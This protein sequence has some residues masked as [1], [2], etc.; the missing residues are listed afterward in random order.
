MEFGSDQKSEAMEEEDSIATTTQEGGAQAVS[1]S[2]EGFSGGDTWNT[3]SKLQNRTT[4]TTMAYA[5]AVETTTEA[6]NGTQTETMRQADGDDGGPT[7]PIRVEQ[8]PQSTH[9]AEEKMS[10]S[11]SGIIEEAKLNGQ[12]N[13]DID[14]EMTALNIRAPEPPTANSETR[15]PPSGAGEIRH[16]PYQETLPGEKQTDRKQLLPSVI[17]MTPDFVG[18]PTKQGQQQQNLSSKTNIKVTDEKVETPKLPEQNTNSVSRGRFIVF[19]EKQIPVTS[20]KKIVSANE[21]QRKRASFGSK[22]GSGIGSSLAITPTTA[23]VSISTSHL[24]PTAPPQSY[25]PQGQ[26]LGPAQG[27]VQGQAQGQGQ[28]PANPQQQ[29][30]NSLRAVQV[31]KNTLCSMGKELGYDTPQPQAPGAYPQQTLQQAA[32]MPRHIQP[33]SIETKDSEKLQTKLAGGETTTAVTAAASTAVTASSQPNNA[34]KEL[35][36]KKKELNA[37]ELEKRRLEGS[38]KKLEDEVEDLKKQ[39]IVAQQKLSRFENEK[40]KEK[41]L[42]DDA[43]GALNESKPSK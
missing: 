7:A 25:F 24:T 22:V 5:T 19:E 27:Q 36:E 13:A 35:E 6:L 3:P 20:W 23:T 40:W 14:N 42:D 33:S 10:A 37:S 16:S 17:R 8:Q 30:R 12:M 18:P 38:K 32:S 28:A 39:L 34:L 9:T 31:I 43:E 4:T 41:P 26:G 11:K 29:F 21:K 1:S 15:K 2:N